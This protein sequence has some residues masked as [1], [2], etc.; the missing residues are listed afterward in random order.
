MKDQLFIPQKIKVGYQMRPDTYTKKLAYVIYWDNKGVL[1]KETGWE[2]WRDKK[3]EPN[4]FENKPFSGFVLN[5]DVKRSSEW[6]GNG[7]NMIRVYDERGIEFEITTGNLLFILMT[8]DCL[9]RGLQ[10]DFV[11]SW[12]GTELVLLPTGC[13]EYKNSVQYTSLQSG[14][15]G[16]KNLVL[17]GS[18][19]TKKQQDLIYLGKYDWHVFSYTY[20][21]NYNSY[22]LSKTYKAFIFVDDK[23]GFIPLKGLKNLAIQNSDVCVSNYA[24]LMDNFNKSPH[25]TKPKSLIAKEKKFT[26]TD[27]QVNANINNWYGRI[28]R[29]EGFVLEENGKFVDHVINFEKTYNRENGK[30][31]HTGYYTLQPVNNIE[32]KDGIKYSHIN[33]NYNDRMKYTREQLQEM[34]FVELNVQMESG[35][36]HEFH[37]F[38]KLQSGY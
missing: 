36:E 31:D 34:D 28:E 32:M 25:A 38:M 20:G 15:I 9:K 22:Y 16:V 35:A 14:S 21:A 8:T 2:S 37:K 6:F 30:Y 17:G 18:Y 29:G 23:G 1:R 13:D 5:K 7:R 27:E 33:S 10:G 11:Y 19:K 4:E 26:M 12:Y 24:E 3:I